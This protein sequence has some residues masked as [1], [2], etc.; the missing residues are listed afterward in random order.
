MLRAALILWLWLGNTSF[1]QDVA[2]PSRL[3]IDGQM[4]DGVSYV[5]HDDARVKIQHESGIANLLISEL[6]DELQAMLGFDAGKAAASLGKE[7]E[8]RAA[9]IAAAEAAAQWEAE[10]ADRAKKRETATIAAAEAEA[11]R[12]AEVADQ[13]KRR[14]TAREMAFDVWRSS[15]EGI[16]VT[17]CKPIA[18]ST[19]GNDN[20]SRVGLGGPVRTW[21]E[22]TRGS[23]DALLKGYGKPAA[24]GDRIKVKAYEVGVREVDDSGTMRQLRV[25][26]AVE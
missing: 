11:Q 23:Q 24:E 19:A 8:M 7:T 5:S 20:M 16:L 13:A 15:P 1:A 6:P 25:Y 12:K 22:W 4:F 3:E 21:T 9:A 18:R 17:V 2:L 14:K 10:V 26:E